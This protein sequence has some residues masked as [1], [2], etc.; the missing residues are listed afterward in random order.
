M[1]APMVRRAQPARSA[2]K[3]PAGRSGSTRTR[4]PQAARTAI[5][6]P[7]LRTSLCCLLSLRFSCRFDGSIAHRAR[8]RA[9]PAS[10]AEAEP[11]G[12]LDVAVARHPL[13]VAHQLVA[14]VHLE[15]QAVP[16]RVVLRM[17][18]QVARQ[19]GDVLGQDR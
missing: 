14:P 4:A 12:E 15:Q 11:V 10:L 5:T 13:K 2:R 16:A 3:P 18:L 19:L 17:A 6:S 7:C 8:T 9:S 1:P